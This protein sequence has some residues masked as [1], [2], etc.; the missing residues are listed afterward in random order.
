L[1]LNRK[2][3]WNTKVDSPRIRQSRDLNWMEVWAGGI[4]QLDA[5]A[6]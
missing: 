2:V 1:Q 4:Q 3:L 6:N 5:P